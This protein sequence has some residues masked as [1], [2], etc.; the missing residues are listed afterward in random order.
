MINVETQ[1]TDPAS[2]KRGCRK[3][4]RTVNVK[5]ETVKPGH[6]SQTGLDTKTD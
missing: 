4:S 5:T 2:G 1:A 6:E 3:T